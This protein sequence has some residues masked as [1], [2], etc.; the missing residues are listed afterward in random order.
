MIWMLP[1][2]LRSYLKKFQ[3]A[4]TLPCRQTGK[5]QNLSGILTD[6]IQ[7]TITETGPAFDGF[8]MPRN[9]MGMA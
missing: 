3:L 5:F 2:C 9:I 6:N 4:S 1:G 8:Q 7:I